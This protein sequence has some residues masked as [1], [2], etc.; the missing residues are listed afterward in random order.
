MTSLAS[1]RAATYAA[2]IR[3]QGALLQLCDT[4]LT[5]GSIPT[6]PLLTV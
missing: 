1:F 4:L 3:R 6:L 5:I 2:F